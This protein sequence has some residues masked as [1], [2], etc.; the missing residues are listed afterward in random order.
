MSPEVAHN[1][2]YWQTRIL[3]T[4]L[5][6]YALYY[7]VRDNLNQAMPAMEKD[8]G[9]S[10]TD[11]GLFLTL[12]GLLY[13]VSKFVMG[14]FV[15]RLNA[16]WF[17]AAGLLAAALLN[18]AFG[19]SSSVW[20]LGVIWMFNGWAQGLGFPPAARLMTH[21]FSPKELA[22]KMSIWNVSHCVGLGLIVL[23]CGYLIQW[24]WGWRACFY[25]P[26]GLALVGAVFLA[27]ALRDTPES[28]GLPEVTGMEHRGAAA[29]DPVGLWDTLTRYVLSNPWIWLVSVANF[30]VYIVR[31][32]LIKWGPTFL[33]QARQLTPEQSGWLVMTIEIGGGALGMVSCGWLTDR[34]FGGRGA[35]TCLFY[36]LL[37][38]ACLVAFQSLPVGS[39]FAVEAALLVGAGFALYGPQALIGII[40]ANLGTKKAAA[41]AGGFTGM[42]GYFSTVVSGVGVGWLVD[43]YGWTA[44][45]NLF[46]AA[47]VAG[48]VVFALAW[49][50][51]AHGYK[52]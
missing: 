15:D 17:M 21:W 25:L 30:F 11:L 38:T 1:F 27:V 28:L 36:M 9:I 7:F 42:F 31:F 47:S 6:G 43:R 4:A 26:A 52:V 34:V 39:P 44:G 29:G 14:M 49:K 18:V 32:G 40:G 22:T 13:G 8:L 20:L 51:P 2:R 45:Y 23:L 10:K 12:N 16:R 3:V 5:I 37:C 50:A 33:Q 19:A 41:T 46:V 35:R 24:G 48:V